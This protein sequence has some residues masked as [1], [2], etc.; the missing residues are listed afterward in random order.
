MR[1]G[2]FYTLL[3]QA[4]TLLLYFV[5]S[6]LMTRILGDVGRG[7]YALITNFGALLA[8]LMGMN[9]VGGVTYF[10]ARTGEG[11]ADTIG[12][13]ATLLLL[14][15]VVSPAILGLVFLS[16]PLTSL[17]MPDER[18]HWTYWA[19]VYL[20]VVQSLVNNSV[21]G[22][23]LG[24]KRFAAL[25]TMSILNAALSAVGMLAIFLLPRDPH[26]ALPL[27]LG[28]TVTT[29]TLVT[30]TWCVMYAV[31]V[32]VVPRPV[33]SWAVM[34]PVLAFSMVGHLSNIINLINYRFDV[35]VVDQYQGAAQLGLYAVAVGLGQL[36]FNVPDPFSRVVQPFLFGQQRNEMLAR[37]KAVA[38]LNFTVLVVLA[39]GMAATAPWIV[40]LLFGAEFAPSVE[41]L[42]LLLPGIVLA[43]T[44]KLLAQLV[45]QGGL[46]RF[47]LMATAI[48]A[49]VTIILDLLLIPAW[50][51]AG[52][53][54]ASTTA[55]AVVLSITLSTIRFRM[56]VPIHDLFILRAADM[57]K[58]PLLRTREQ[59]GK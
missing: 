5:A 51:I 53:A 31:H 6:T 55:Y 43:G 40:P 19:F 22:V 47:N 21:S 41:P 46:Q 38:R 52:A 14:N 57:A 34:R 37:F 27:V 7:E 17:F 13:A 16:S 10:V 9:I 44:T 36:L 29:G 33:W 59:A 25:N 26:E 15:I 42:H 24:M 11:M 20:S 3:T 56:G 8:M 23:L 12:V 1:R 45:I 2:L 54:V 39:L 35:W 58:F 30:L 28:V 32:K 49:A 4:P 48:A 50:G 18:L